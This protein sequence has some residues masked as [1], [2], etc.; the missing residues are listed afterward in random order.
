MLPSAVSEL[1]VEA[2]A[3]GAFRFAL[4]PEPAVSIG[5]RAFADCTKLQYIY[6]YDK[7]TDIA[8]DAF[9]DKEKLTIFGVGLPNGEKSVAQSYA[10]EHGF[11]F[12]P[13]SFRS[14]FSVI[15]H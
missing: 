4:L 14:Q 12:I 2:F 1:G 8:A 11:T 9:G 7:V 15:D 5:S 10:E 6:I 3:G 13:I